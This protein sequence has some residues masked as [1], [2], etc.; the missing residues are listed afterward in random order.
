MDH[1]DYFWN[2][3]C[4]YALDIH[5]FICVAAVAYVLINSLIRKIKQYEIVLFLTA[6]NLFF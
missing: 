2:G 4:C 6:K 1:V 3:D 5:S